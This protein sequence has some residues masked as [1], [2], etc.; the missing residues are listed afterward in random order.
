MMTRRD[1]GDSLICE[2]AGHLH[3]CG[4]SAFTSSVSAPGKGARAGPCQNQIIAVATKVVG[5]ESIRDSA[6][7][8]AY[9]LTLIKIVE[10]AVDEA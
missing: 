4:V 9:Q 3:R 7:A 10:G 5:H 2:C 8:E 6:E 1:G